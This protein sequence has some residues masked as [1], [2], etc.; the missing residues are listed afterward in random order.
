MS[1]AYCHEVPDQ[2]GDDN[3]HVIVRCQDDPAVSIR[4]HDRSFP[5]EYGICFAVEARAQGLHAEL[6]GGLLHRWVTS[7]MACPGGGLEGCCCAQALP[8]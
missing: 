2:S 6:P 7:E 4:L 3:L 5:D 1:I 8:P